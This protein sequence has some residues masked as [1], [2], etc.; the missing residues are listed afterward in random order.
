MLRVGPRLP[1]SECL[2][3]KGGALLRGTHGVHRRRWLR[4]IPCILRVERA[5]SAPGLSRDESALHVF[6]RERSLLLCV[7][8]EAL[9]AG[10]AD[11]KL[12]DVLVVLGVSA[13]RHPIRIRFVPEKQT[14]GFQTSLPALDLLLVR[15]AV[16]GAGIWW[17]AAVALRRLREPLIIER[18]P[19]IR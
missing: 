14:S 17:V 18:V 3:F 13:R 15:M 6:D 16:I 19:H 12:A 8:V 2:L 7:T 5:K 1:G 9:C 10:G 11:P 4:L